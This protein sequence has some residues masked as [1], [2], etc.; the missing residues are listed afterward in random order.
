[1]GTPG[2]GENEHMRTGIYFD[3][4]LQPALAGV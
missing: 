4:E 2:G 1:V 3:T